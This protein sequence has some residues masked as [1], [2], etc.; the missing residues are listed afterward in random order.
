LTAAATSFIY[1]LTSEGEMKEIDLA[2]MAVMILAEAADQ[3]SWYAIQLFNSAADTID[4][5]WQRLSFVHSSGRDQVK[6]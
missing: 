3:G 1:N 6:R 2:A 4:G 5:F